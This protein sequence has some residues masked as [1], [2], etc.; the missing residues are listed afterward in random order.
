MAR[1]WE[2]PGGKVEAGE[3]LGAA[4]ER[5]IQ[6]ELGIRVRVGD[7]F[8]TVD[9]DYSTKS[10]RLYFFDCTVLEGEARA[11]EV[12]D[13]RWVRPQ[14][15]CNYDIPTCRRPAHCEI[16][17]IPLIASCLH[18]LVPLSSKSPFIFAAFIPAALPKM[19]LHELRIQIKLNCP[20]H[21]LPGV[22]LRL[23]I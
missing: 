22:A 14:D 8:F 9:H 17:V 16:A 18:N 4:L 2:F 15:L 5:E 6:E 11:L 3:S 19:L 7:E 13:F 12:A 21:R 1:L 10:I 20:F 23:N